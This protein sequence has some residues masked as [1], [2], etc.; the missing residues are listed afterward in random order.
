[1]AQACGRRERLGAFVAVLSGLALAVVVEFGKYFV[2]ERHPSTTSL[3][4]Q[5]GGAWLGYK[6]A[7]LATHAL[8]PVPV[9]PSETQFLPSPG[10]VGTEPD[11]GAPSWNPLAFPPRHDGGSSSRSILPNVPQRN[12]D[13]K[14]AFLAWFDA[15]PNWFQ[16]ALMAL[17]AFLVPVGIVLL[18]RA[19][20]LL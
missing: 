18:C 1:V 10:T 9:V 4:I 8:A 7:R 2:P 3:L 11:S 20:G 12:Q 6:V 19:I 13:R 14:N 5:V 17:A 15:Q 16:I